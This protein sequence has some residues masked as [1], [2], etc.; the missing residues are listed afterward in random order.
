MTNKNEPLQRNKFVKKNTNKIH[1][2]KSVRR[3][4]SKIVSNINNSH[5]CS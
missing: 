2:N 1:K 4:F 3:K 5:A